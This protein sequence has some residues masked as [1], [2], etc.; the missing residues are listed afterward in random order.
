MDQLVR[1]ASLR[2]LQVFEAIARHRSFRRAADELS[3]AQPTVS[4]QFKKVADMVGLPLFEQIGKRIY[5]TETGE[6][7]YAACGEIF[8]TMGRLGT[9]I[10]DIRG[11]R[12]G[13]LRL[14]VVTSAKYF[15]THVLGTFCQRHPGVELYLKVAN[16]E[17]LLER[18]AQNQDDL[19]IV[20]EPPAMAETEFRPF[21]SNALVVI[22]RRGHP[23]M[24][25]RSVSLEKIISEPFIMRERG[26]GTRLALEQLLRQRDL[27]PTTRM[28]LGSNEAIKQAVLNGLGVAALSQYTLGHDAGGLTVLD[29]QGFPL[30]W[31]WYIGHACGK[32]RSVVTRTFLDFLENEAGQITRLSAAMTV[33]HQQAY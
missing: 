22:A 19:Y 3:L 14:A 1:R 5:L 25:R 29:V 32:Q 10:A 33:R 17:R 27:K 26:S 30:R 21:L 6:A 2:Q 11:L 8:A 16:R 4:M 28:E 7:L 20:G 12:Q 13:H 24:H 23:L 18:M 15:T 31:D 9:Q